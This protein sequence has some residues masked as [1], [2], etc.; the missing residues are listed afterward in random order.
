[1]TLTTLEARFICIP[2]VIDMVPEYAF[3]QFEI[4]GNQSPVLSQLGNR[5]TELP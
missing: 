3:D 2:I 5:S 4:N 1:M